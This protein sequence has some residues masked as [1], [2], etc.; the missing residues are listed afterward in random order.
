MEETEDTN[1]KV[2]RPMLHIEKT[3]AVPL[4]LA[5]T[6]NHFPTANGSSKSRLL[7]SAFRILETPTSFPSAVRTAITA[8]VDIDVRAVLL[9]C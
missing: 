4:V 6:H 2:I 9:L 8:R 1:V 7:K 5:L 3:W